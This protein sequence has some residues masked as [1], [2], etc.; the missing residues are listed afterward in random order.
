[1]QVMSASPARLTVMLFEHLEVV[2]RRAQLAMTTGQIATRVENLAKARAIVSEL[3]GTL[4]I[5]AGGQ[6]ALD[7]SMLY[8][9]LLG[10]LV[11]VGVRNDAIHLGRMIGIVNEL[12][13]G[14]AG[15]AR[16]LESGNEAAQ[17]VASA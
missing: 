10:E 6:L 17:L 2:L 12:S 11:D 15:A 9:F 5:D 1:M 14:F 8:G 16:Q 4:D 7:L 13:T 3:L